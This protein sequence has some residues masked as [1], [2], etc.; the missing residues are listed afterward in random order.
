MKYVREGPIKS[1]VTSLV[2]VPTRTVVWVFQTPKLILL[3]AVSVIWK[4]R[5]EYKETPGR[6]VIQC[7]DD[8]ILC[9][10]NLKLSDVF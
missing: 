4:R 7:V 5:V 1:Q 6:Q 10:P 3:L 2:S 9:S 8:S